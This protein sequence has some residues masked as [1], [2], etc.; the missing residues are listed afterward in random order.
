MK[1]INHK[2]V[3]GLTV[4]VITGNPFYGIVAAAACRI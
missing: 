2:V 1:W 4:M 3:T